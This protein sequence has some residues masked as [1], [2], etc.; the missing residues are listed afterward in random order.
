MTVALK[1]DCGCGMEQNMEQLMNWLIFCSP[2]HAVPGLRRQTKAA[3]ECYKE[4]VYNGAI[5]FEIVIE[6]SSPNDGQTVFL[7]ENS[8]DKF[9]VWR[10]S[11]ETSKRGMWVK[12]HDYGEKMSEAE[13]RKAYEEECS[14]CSG[15]PYPEVVGF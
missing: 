4:D 14:N 5:G 10:H 7:W 3:V 9:A 6:R 1:C 13:A 8:K 12:L 11:R 2:A 15:E